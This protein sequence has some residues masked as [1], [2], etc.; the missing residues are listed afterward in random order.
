MERADETNLSHADP[1]R[2]ALLLN[3]SVFLHENYQNKDQALQMASQAHENALI[4]LES[5]EKSKSQEATTVLE[6]IR[7]N[8]KLWK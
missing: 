6:F 8:I 1:T 4:E 7:E 5:L 3:F 2:L